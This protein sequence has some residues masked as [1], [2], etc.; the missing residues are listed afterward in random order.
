MFNTKPDGVKKNWKT[1]STIG[2]WSWSRHENIRGE[3]MGEVA[4]YRDEWAKLPKKARALQ[5]L[6]SRWWWWWQ[7]F[8]AAFKSARHLSLSWARLIQSMP[9]HE[10]TYLR[11]SMHSGSAY[12]EFG[13]GHRLTR[14]VMVFLILFWESTSMM[15]PP[16]HFKS[17][18]IHNS[19]IILPQT[20]HNPRY[21]RSRKKNTNENNIKMCSKFIPEPSN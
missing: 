19:P 16:I 13:P 12:F 21:C 6:S 5:G 2:R 20:L 14:T 3:E 7:R 18:P 4:L 10:L 15:L 1:E 8:I 17:F 9:P 11:D